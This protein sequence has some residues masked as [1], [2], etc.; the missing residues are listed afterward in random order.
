MYRLNRRGASTELCGTPFLRNIC[1]LLSA[2]TCI[3]KMRDAIIIMMKFTRDLKGHCIEFK[4]YADGK[5]SGL[6]P[7]GNNS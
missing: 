7:P 4:Y 1:L 2:P 6:T 5:H 3:M